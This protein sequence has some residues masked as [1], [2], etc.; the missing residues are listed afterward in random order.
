MD[1]LKIMDLFAGAGGLSNGFE[2]TDQ[3]EVKMAV[4][5]NKNA[6]ETY[7]KIR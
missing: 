2:Q 5:L 6:R 3:F 7:Q 4:E 1:K